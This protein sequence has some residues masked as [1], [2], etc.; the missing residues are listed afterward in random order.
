[1]MDPAD[2]LLYS[3]AIQLAAEAH[4]GQYRKY[5]GE[6]YILHTIRVALALADKT[7]AVQIAAVLHDTVE[8]TPVT[9]NGV[10]R[11]FGPEVA[12]LVDAVSR[13][14]GETYNQFIDRI[15]EAGRDAITIKLADVT[16]NM[17]NGSPGRS[18]RYSKAY[19]R[20]MAA[21]IA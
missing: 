15:I 20:L 10:G 11:E 1:M 12:R 2:A 21:S 4:H 14:E 9:L 13:R 16:D 7:I 18:D 17:G 6:P 3:R 5:T 19:E 8:D